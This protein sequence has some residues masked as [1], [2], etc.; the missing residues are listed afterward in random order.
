MQG[1]QLL[2]DTVGVRLRRGPL[3]LGSHL[4]DKRESIAASGAFQIVSEAPD[5][6]KIAGSQECPRILNLFFFGEE[7]LWNQLR[8]LLRDSQGPRCLR[9]TRSCGWRE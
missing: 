9:P 3:D 2:G 8:H 1:V 7:I 5:G 6:S 4:L